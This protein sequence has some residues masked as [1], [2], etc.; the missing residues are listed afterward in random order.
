MTPSPFDIGRAIGTNFGNI[1][2]RQ[3]DLSAIDKI[4]SEASQ[5]GSQQDLDSALSQIL[6]RVSPSRQQGA[7]KILQDRSNR[8]QAQQQ[9]ER[10]REALVNAGVPKEL[11]DIDPVTRKELL[12]QK[13]KLDILQSTIGDFGITGKQDRNIEGA[14]AQPVQPSIKDLTD[15]QLIQLTAISDLKEPASKELRRREQERKEE[16][17]DVRAIRKE[18][19]PF[20]QQVTDKADA[21]REGLAN[22]QR[23]QEQIETGNINDPTFATVV[24]S[25]FGE[26]GERLLSPES[27]VYRS[28]LIDEF[29]DLR[30]IFQ[31]Q[32]RVK[33][34]EILE[35]KIPNLY[36][37][38]AQKKAILESRSKVLDL[39]ILKEQATIEVEQENPNLS[40]LQFKKK[41]NERF[42][43][44][45]KPLSDQVI[46]EHKAIIQDAEDTKRK[47]L[48]RNDPEGFKIINDIFQEAKGDRK[49]AFKIAEDRG[50]TFSRA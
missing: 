36:L 9:K 48:D 31:G 12:K 27:V 49:K 7:M 19:L 47:P 41:V 39:D 23:L 20:I 32:T 37:T 2:E 29:K 3:T 8:I 5:S 11:A 26:L 44:L 30:Q 42:N 25:I 4:L 18:V 46:N 22:K 28:G 17:A 15:D 38:D 21:A 43:E 13:G 10:E 45:V 14:T 24:T 16:K 40:L 6:T 1:Q 33:E 50:Y 35:K 34:I